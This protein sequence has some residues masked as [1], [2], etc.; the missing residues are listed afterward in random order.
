MDAVAL[1]DFEYSPDGVKMA[2]VEKGKRIDFPDNLFP[3]MMAEG[4]VKEFSF[5]DNPDALPLGFVLLLG[6]DVFPNILEVGENKLPLGDLVCV[7]HIAS[8]LSKEDWNALEQEDRDKRLADALAALVYLDD[9]ET[10]DAADEATAAAEDAPGEQPADDPGAEPKAEPE[11]EVD[12][13]E[14][15]KA[16]KVRYTELAKKKPHYKWVASTL[17]KKIKELEELAAK[18]EG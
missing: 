15:F 13:D 17:I 7:A 11:P 1:K 3:G 16:L 8:F 4:F 12:G 9:P 18:V 5:E 14:A 10:G 2:Q 6:S